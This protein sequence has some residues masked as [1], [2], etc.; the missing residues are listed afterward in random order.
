MTGLPIQAVLP[1]IARGVA[2]KFRCGPDRAARR[3]QDHFRGPGT[4]RRTLVQRPD[5]AHVS[6]PRRGAR[7]LQSV[8]RNCLVRRRARGSA[9]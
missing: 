2:R 7:P 9:T 1:A 3:R 5:P 6:P 4:P 8:W